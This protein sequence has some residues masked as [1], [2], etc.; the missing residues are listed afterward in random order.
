VRR[1]RVL[2]LAAL[3]LAGCG[4]QPPAPPPAAARDAAAATPAA[5]WTALHAGLGREVPP[6]RRAELDDVLASPRVDPIAR[7][8]SFDSPVVRG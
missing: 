1:A 5:G 3:I 4:A 2:F 8:G 6:G 7:H